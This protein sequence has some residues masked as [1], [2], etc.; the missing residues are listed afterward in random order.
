MTHWISEWLKL[1]TSTPTTVQHGNKRGLSACCNM[2]SLQSI[3]VLTVSFSSYIILV[4]QC[5]ISYS[6]PQFEQWCDVFLW[7]KDASHYH[8]RKQT[9]NIQ[10]AS[11]LD[12]KT[13]SQCDIKAA[14]YTTVTLATTLA[15]QKGW[16]ETVS[17]FLGSQRC[18]MCEVVAVCGYFRSSS[19][20]RHV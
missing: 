7:F 15:T 16:G 11:T 4:A 18:G 8:W 6:S 2:C 14:H 20:Y 13:T 19:A 9:T 17:A 1:L 10:V 12:A 5:C 3:W